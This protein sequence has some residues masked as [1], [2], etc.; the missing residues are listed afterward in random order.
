[1]IPRI[2]N[3]VKQAHVIK[4]SGRYFSKF[5]KKGQVQTAWSLAGAEVFLSSLLP[6]LKKLDEK[7]KKYTV[8]RIEVIDRVDCYPPRELFKL[9]H[10]LERMM[11]NSCTYHSFEAYKNFNH[12]AKY[13]LVEQVMLTTMQCHEANLNS[14][15][16]TANTVDFF[17]RFI[18]TEREEV[19][20]LAERLETFKE[21]KAN[22]K[23]F[24]EFMDD[25]PF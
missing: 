20:A 12:E 9:R 7:G 23:V 2:E 13:N 16:S 21:K 8:E 18:G 5:G 19:K 1:M 11:T 24:N 15:H 3:P 10:R 17:F 25:C 6:V 22:P 4:I 14:S